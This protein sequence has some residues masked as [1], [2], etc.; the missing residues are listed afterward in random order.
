MQDPQKK[1]KPESK[2]ATAYFSVFLT[3][4]YPINK[5]KK[6]IV[7]ASNNNMEENIDHNI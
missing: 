5:I 3:H 4:K 7:G 6:R 1:S 2:H